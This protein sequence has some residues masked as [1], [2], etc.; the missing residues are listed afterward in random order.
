MNK[1]NN[2][3]NAAQLAKV[4]SAKSA[5]ECETVTES[6]QSESERNT[7][8]ITLNEESALT[9]INKGVSVRD[10]EG[11][12]YTCVAFIPSQKKE[13]NEGVASEGAMPFH[14]WQLV[15]EKG[16]IVRPSK[17]SEKDYLT[18]PQLKRLLGLN[19]LTSGKSASDSLNFS[20]SIT[21]SDRER[22]HAKF[23]NLLNAV[24]DKV[25]AIVSL[26]EQKGIEFNSE[27]VTLTEG[28]KLAFTLAFT[29]RVNAWFDN[30]LKLAV[31]RANEKAQKAITKGNKAQSVNNFTKAFIVVETLKELELDNETICAK[32]VAKG[33]APNTETA[34]LIL[35]TYEKQQSVTE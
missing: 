25:H 27:C 24:N 17:Q 7:D 20:H 11:N 26:C 13:I 16:N 18:S 8:A 4:E 19:V 6:A 29:E 30:E 9:L 2:K 28:A 15:D 5:T 32:L 33:L 23:T 31:E 34:T 3:R 35:E 14:R 12:I 1:K 10:K 21:E 22:A